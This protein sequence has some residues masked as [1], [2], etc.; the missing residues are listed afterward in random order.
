[1]YKNPI[2][3]ESDQNLVCLKRKSFLA[4]ADLKRNMI[5]SSLHSGN[6]VEI[7]DPDVAFD[8]SRFIH[9]LNFSH[10]V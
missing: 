7:N 4:R 1:M 9:Y 5:L 10:F 8:F 6:L 2:E 3:D